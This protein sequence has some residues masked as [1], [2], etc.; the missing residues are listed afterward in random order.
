MIKFATVRLGK[1]SVEDIKRINSF[2][3]GIMSSPI[4]IPVVCTQVPSE[5]EINTIIFL[6]FGS[7]N[8]KGIPTEWKQGFKAVGTVEDIKRGESFNSETTTKIKIEYIFSEAINRLDILRDAASP[9]F[10]CA[11]LPIIGIDDH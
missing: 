1:T 3:I 8:A 5:L 6:W 10:N 9:Y 11:N 7:D 4:V 2:P